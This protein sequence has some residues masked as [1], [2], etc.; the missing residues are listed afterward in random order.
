MGLQVAKVHNIGALMIRMGFGLY[1]T[2]IVMRSPQNPI[3]IIKA[4]TL[5]PDVA[6]DKLSGQANE[7]FEFRTTRV[8]TLA[9]PSI[10]CSGISF[11]SLCRPGLG[12]R[13]CLST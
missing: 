11:R 8:G 1:Y 2:I 12:C 10:S 6:K 5:W 4:P 3:L 13:V 7:E 9:S